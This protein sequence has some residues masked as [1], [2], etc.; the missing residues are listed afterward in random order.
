M[1]DVPRIPAGATALDTILDEH[2]KIASILAEAAR[3]GRKPLCLSPKTSDSVSVEI[4]QAYTFLVDLFK[5][6]Q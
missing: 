1:S 5:D 2:P 6:I 4:E 3:D